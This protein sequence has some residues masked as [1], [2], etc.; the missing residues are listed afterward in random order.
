MANIWRAAMEWQELNE[1]T[2]IL[3]LILAWIIAKKPLWFK[4]K[5]RI[6]ISYM[7][8]V[9]QVHSFPWSS[10]YMIHTKK[11]SIIGLCLWRATDSWPWKEPEMH[12]LSS[13][14]REE[15]NNISKYCNSIYEEV[16][17]LKITIFTLDMQLRFQSLWT[18]WKDFLLYS[19]NMAHWAITTYFFCQQRSHFLPR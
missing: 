10:Y 19:C 17:L 8:Y 2:D 16:I 18:P 12:L 13:L 15:H 7:T 6:I 9:K 1:S 4:R 5:I 11:K 14:N 3:T